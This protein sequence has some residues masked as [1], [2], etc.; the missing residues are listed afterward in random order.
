MHRFFSR[1]LLLIAVAI[2]GY[3][4]TLEDSRFLDD[5]DNDGTITQCPDIEALFLS[6]ATQILCTEYEYDGDSRQ[7]CMKYSIK[8]NAQNV[9]LIDAKYLSGITDSNGNDYCAYEDAT[10][11]FY[12]CHNIPEL[13]EDKYKQS[14]KFRICPKNF[15]C[16]DLG[17]TPIEPSILEKIATDASAKP[18][19]C[20]DLAKSLAD[21]VFCGGSY[22][23]PR[24]DNKYC[25]ASDDCKGNNAG[26]NCN[27]TNGGICQM[28]QCVCEDGEVECNGICVDNTFTKTLSNNKACG[29]TCDAIKD[30]T[31][32]NSYCL[33][34]ECVKAMCTEPE[35]QCFIDGT[36]QCIDTTSNPQHCG[37]CLNSCIKNRIPNAT[38]EICANNLCQY[39]CDP[40]YINVGSGNTEDT[41]KCI[42]PNQDKDYCGAKSADDPGK[43]CT[44]G[45]VCVD[46]SCVQNSCS[47]DTPNLCVVDG[48]NV[49]KNIHSYDNDHCGACNYKCS[50]Y[51]IQNASAETC[52]KGAC[53]YVCA[54]G[55]VNVGSGNTLQTIKCIDP[56]TDNNYCGAKSASHPGTSC[57]NGKVCVNGSCFTNSCSGSTPTMCVVNGTNTCKNVN[58]D[59]VN[60][61]GSCGFKCSEH[62]IPNATSHSCSS[63][64]CQYT[65]S[66]GYV[67]VGRG[68]TSQTIKCIDPR[69]D[70][71]YCG[72]SSA[73]KPGTS[74]YGGKVCVNGQC[75]TNSC[76]GYTP[77]LCV[78]N[79]TNTCKNVNSNDAGNCG[80]CN[81]KCAEHAIPNAT[82]NACMNG[83]CQY[84]C[85]NGFV[86][87]GKGSTS[88]T[89]KCIDPKTDNNYCGATSAS[90]P[91][92]SCTG[93]KVCVN[94]SCV[95]NSCSGSTPDLCVVSGS[96]VCKNVNGTDA[97]HCGAC[98]YK[99]SEHS[100][101]HATSNT[102]SS[103]KCIYTCETGYK[104]IGSGTDA[105]TIQCV[106]ETVTCSSSQTNCNDVCLA[107]S[108]LDSAFHVEVNEG[109]CTCIEGY[110]NT[111]DDWADGC[112][113][114][115]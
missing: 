31:K 38:S 20:V 72:A 21:R 107:T 98:N 102:C 82:S 16:Q 113:A 108:L 3:G 19:A 52:V 100:L 80:A 37:E 114:T 5:F 29:A 42:D 40:G 26:T 18:T 61:C 50:E 51:A 101:S 93:G 43:S 74:C 77:N 30:C 104:N 1:S 35:K 106:S 112:E 94:G 88:Q 63:G 27:D 71:K 15:V 59:D 85:L 78:V 75:A 11:E 8:L 69:T 76:S 67:N 13:L 45:S 34:G 48:K 90:K 64:A 53:Q 57:T 41:I 105:S 60:H 46:G 33:S 83:N 109:I 12:I 110:S 14:L 111:N 32:D 23:D 96:N 95:T 17:N 115:P 9:S 79:G 55:F 92:T 39:E 36:P 84:T 49:C 87:V 81:Y 6:D 4:C 103:G 62:S 28:G 65:C 25:G 66:M 89:I 56:K 24:S 10:H 68:N 44:G 54:T 58:S 73:S 91:G 70:D 97:N 7:Q 47:G 99:C 22:I 2:A 86:N